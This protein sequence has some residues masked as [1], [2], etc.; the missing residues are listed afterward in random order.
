HGARAVDAL[1]EGAFELV[2]KPPLGEELDSFVQ[3]LSQKTRAA[4]IARRSPARVA[5][6]A[7]PP[8]PAPAPRSLVAGARRLVVGRCSAGGPRALAELLP[9]LPGRLGAGTLIVQHM[10]PGFTGSLAERLDRASKLTVREATA[11]DHPTADEALIA[12]GGSHLRL[13]D[14]RTAVLSDEPAVGGLR[15]RADL[16]LADAAKLYGDRL[17]LVVLTGMG[18]DGLEGAREVKSRGGRVLAEAESSC[19]VY[20]MPRAIVEAELADVV[21][22]LERLP[23]VIAAEAGRAA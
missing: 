13:T 21:L 15:P 6:A 18:R 7:A 22:P 3:E 23:E 8:T 2:A 14:S 4:A 16:T 17:G 5:A 19:T 9:R 12:P 11:G 20:G 1:A 10:P